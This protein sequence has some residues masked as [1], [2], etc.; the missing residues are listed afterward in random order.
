VTDRGVSTVLDAA[1]C[2][3]LVSGAVAT[4]AHVRTDPEPSR[5]DTADETADRLGASTARV[6]Y[7]LATPDGDVERSAALPI[8]ASAG[9]DADL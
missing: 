4:L 3:L 6:N 7:A 1:L 2:L 5:P 9:R 8:P